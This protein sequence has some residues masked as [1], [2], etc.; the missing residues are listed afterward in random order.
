M[1]KRYDWSTDGLFN[2][3]IVKRIGF[4]KLIIQNLTLGFCMCGTNGT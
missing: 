4:H 2:D 1:V 3:T